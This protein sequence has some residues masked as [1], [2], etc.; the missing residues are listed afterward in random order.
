MRNWLRD[1]TQSHCQWLS[2]WMVIGDKRWPP[3]VSTGIY[4]DTLVSHQL[5]FFFFFSTDTVSFWR[6]KFLKIYTLSISPNIIAN[7]SDMFLIIFQV[8]Q[9]EF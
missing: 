4:H 3:G 6:V 9:D 2:V 7:G 1:N 5:L 8:L